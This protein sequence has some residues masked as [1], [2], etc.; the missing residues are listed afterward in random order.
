MPFSGNTQVD[1]GV[2]SRA[3]GRALRSMTILAAAKN[4]GLLHFMFDLDK[5]TML[6]VERDGTTGQMNLKHTRLQVLPAYE[7]ELYISTTYPELRTIRN[8]QDEV[9]I[10]T[11]T[12]NPNQFRTLKGQIMHVNDAIVVPKS[13]WDKAVNRPDG[14]DSVAQRHLMAKCRGTA[15]SL[16]LQIWGNTE[17][18]EVSLAGIP[19]IVSNSNTYMGID[20][21][22][23]ENAFWRAETVSAGGAFNDLDPVIEVQTQIA[24]NGGI[25]DVICADVSLFGWIRKRL[26]AYGNLATFYET[27]KFGGQQLNYAGSKIVLDRNVPLDSSGY[28]QAFC[29]STERFIAYTDGNPGCTDFQEERMLNNAYMAKE[30]WYIGLACEKPN[31]QGFVTGIQAPA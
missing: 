26:E 7:Y 12:Y 4:N 5:A 22:L 28:R 6:P 18:S 20:R 31:E 17:Q 10:R 29:L 2:L 27:V 21:S 30:D 14:G 16:A 3:F 23:D 24:S 8:G 9:A 19:F 11:L 1:T 25:G 15:D 13:E